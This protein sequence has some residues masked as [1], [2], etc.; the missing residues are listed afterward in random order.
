MGEKIDMA[1]DAI[2]ATRVREV[3]LQKKRISQKEMF[4]GA[5]FMVDGNMCCGVIKDKLVVRVIREEYDKL[6]LRPHVKPMDF[7]GKPLRGFV[8]VLPSGLKR[9]A[10]LKA[11]VEKGLNC[12]SSPS[13]KRG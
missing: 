4:G 12:V 13:L 1:Y 9:R 7:T 3:L 6:L 2:L 10:S 8:Y 11:W 5:C